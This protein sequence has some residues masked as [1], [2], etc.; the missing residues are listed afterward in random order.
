MSIYHSVRLATIAAILSGLFVTSVEATG[1]G[2]EPF[3]ATAGITTRPTGHND[4]CR[5]NPSE[6]RVKTRVGPRVH[7]TAERWNELVEV[8]NLVN[9]AVTPV[10]DEELF[11]RE[12]VWVYP[13]NKGDCEDFVLEKRRDLIKRGWPVGS[14]LITVVRQT[15]G[16][17]HA[18]LTVL[19]DR[20]DLVLDNL[21]PQV[22]V[23]SQTEYQYVK[24]QSEADSGRWIAIDDARTSSVGSLAR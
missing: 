22:K 6:C 24:R 10:T 1:A 11:G 9:W 19:T 18:V 12:E 15:N 20:G 13:T 23:W 2:H 21:E 4:F 7:L 8:N 3:M 5:R 16:D 14:L 17:G